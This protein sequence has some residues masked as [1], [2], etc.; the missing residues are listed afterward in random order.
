MAGHMMDVP[1]TALELTSP[2]WV[3]SYRTPPFEELYS[4]NNKVVCRFPGTKYTAGDID[5]Y[6]YDTGPVDAKSSWPIDQ[7]KDLPGDGSMFVGEN[8]YMFLPHVAAPQLLPR[9]KLAEAEKEFD[10]QV[11][12]VEGLNHYHQFIDACL[13][14]GKTTTP[15]E[16]SGRLTET[17]LMGTVTNPFPKEKLVWDARALK[18][19]NKPEANRHLRRTYRDGW[20]VEGL[21]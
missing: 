18:F 9:E 20:H 11:G 21:G 16:Y 14:K 19:S 1:F 15:F 17:I 7:R 10:R 13:G 12:P 2:K 8:G 4:P 5:Y 6:W 3:I